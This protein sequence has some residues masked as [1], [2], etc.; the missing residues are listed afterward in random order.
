M[1]SELF[2]EAIRY[3]Q[4]TQSVYQAILQS[5]GDRTI[6]V[7]HNIAIPGRSGVKHQIDVLWRFL[8]AG[9][10]HKVLIECKNYSSNVSLEKVRN[11]HSVINDIGSAQGVIVTKTGFQKGAVTYA[12]HHGIDLKLLRK[13]NDADWEGRIKTISITITAKS[14]I[15]TRDRPVE[16]FVGLAPKDD[17]Q[18][19]RIEKLIRDRNLNAISSPST[20]FLNSLGQI[21]TEELRWW[22]PERLETL[23]KEGEGPFTQDISVD[24][25]YIRINVGDAKEELVKVGKISAN[26]YVGSYSQESIIHGEEVVKAILRDYCTGEVEHVRR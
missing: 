11:F 15:S 18:K 20:C 2:E 7:E 4:L 19:K 16:V 3:E 6:R 23:R 12:E 17:A 25:L 14:V 10:E 21:T 13:P 8:K 9:I 5:E 24:N 1:N 26:Y 22:L